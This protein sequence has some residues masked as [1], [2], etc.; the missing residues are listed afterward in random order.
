LIAREDSETRTYTTPMRTTIT[1]L[2]AMAV[3]EEKSKSVGFLLAVL[4]NVGSPL[5]SS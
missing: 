3:K 4:L 1:E 2:A 5:E